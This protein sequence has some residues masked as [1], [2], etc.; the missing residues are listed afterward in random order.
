MFKAIFGYFLSK[1]ITCH[2]KAINLNITHHNKDFRLH[3]RMET[4][5]CTSLVQLN[6]S[7]FVNFQ[8]FQDYHLLGWETLEH[9]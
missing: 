7:P 2:I 9:L 8:F 3:S 6:C 1:I 5:D 4:F